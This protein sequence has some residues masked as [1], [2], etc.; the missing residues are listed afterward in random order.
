ML[1]LGLS[2][3]GVE[4]SEGRNVYRTFKKAVNSGSV[5]EGM[6]SLLVATMRAP[7]SCKNVGDT[8]LDIPKADSLSQVAGIYV[9]LLMDI[10][11]SDI[12]VAIALEL[13]I[14]LS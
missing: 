8:W 12:F 14:R 7:V 11:L 5:Y 1:Q 2:D 9:N 10:L 4:A 3:E 6:K 13:V